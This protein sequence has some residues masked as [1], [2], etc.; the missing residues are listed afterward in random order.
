M[1]SFW[2]PPQRRHSPGAYRP[3]PRWQSTLYVVG[4]VVMAVAVVVGL[5]VLAAFVY[6]AIALNNMGNNK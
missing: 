6:L 5:A 3:V 4:L 1:S 2:P